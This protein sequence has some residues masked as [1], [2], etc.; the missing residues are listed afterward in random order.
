MLYLGADRCEHLGVIR[1]DLFLA[2][3]QL[4]LVLLRP[5]VDGLALRFH[6]AIGQLETDNIE[7]TPF[8]VKS[9]GACPKPVLAKVRVFVLQITTQRKS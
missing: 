7:Q 6:L 9:S 3:L 4:L 2:A 1:L 8:F 5:G